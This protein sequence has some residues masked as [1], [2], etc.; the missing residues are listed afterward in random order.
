M[1]RGKE[2]LISIKLSSRERLAIKPL[3]VIED[4]YLGGPGSQLSC[5]CYSAQEAPSVAA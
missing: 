2:S 4:A 1:G 3:K 5:N